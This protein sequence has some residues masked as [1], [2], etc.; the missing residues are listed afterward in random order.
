MENKR[1]KFLTAT[2]AALAV[3][4]V[5]VAPVSAASPFSDVKESHADFDGIATLY[6]AGIIS[7]YPDGTFKPDT[8]VT[9]GQAAK[10]IA[11]A[12]KL[13]TKDVENPNFTDIG[14]SNPYYGSIAALVEL[15]V[16]SGYGDKTFR[17]N[18]TITHGDLAKILSSIPTLPELESVKNHAASENVTR[19]QL[20]TVIAE[21]L[22]KSTPEDGFTLSILHVNDTHARANEL[23]KLATAVKEQRAAKENVLT[24]HAG[25]AFSGTLY[26]NEFHG[27]ADLALL[28]EIGF[29]AMVFGNHE[30]DLGSSPEGHQALVDF[31]KGAKFPF[32]DANTDFS[33]DDKF[34]GLFTDLISSEPENGKIYSGIVK[35][36]NGEKVGIF[37]LTTEETKDIASPNKVKFTNYIEEA[38]KAVAAFEGMGVNKIIALTHIGYNDNPNVDNDILL[39]QNVPGIDVIVGGHDHTKLEEPF[40]VD[41]NTV[42]EAKDATLIV[43]ANEYVKYLGTL[44]VTFDGD[45]VV[46]KYK[47]ELIDLGKVAEDKKL[48]KLLA[49]YKAKVDEVNNKEIGVTLKEALANP[50]SSET[51]L[52][53]VRSNETALGNIIT[54]G[55]LAKA[56][57]F[58]DKTVVMALQNGGGIREAIPAGNITV[59]QVITVLPFGNTLALMDATG[60]ELKAAF[61]VSLKNVP[62]ENGGFLHIAGAKLQYD[63]SKEAGSRVVSVEYFDKAT[64]KYVPLQDDKRYTVATNAYTAKGGDGFDMF[65]KAYEEGR[66]TDLGLSDWENLQEQLLSLKEVKTTTEGR[67]VDLAK[68]Q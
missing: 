50:R 24:L 9:R 52:E 30:F 18:Q 47:G 68:K 17:P 12:L 59:G 5:A 54:D 56:Q 55:M 8:N 4:A 13:D 57:K 32:V 21:A 51:S 62:N 14:A 58:T 33:A 15:K 42:G 16:I 6:A 10:M 60:A 36:I 45:G 11:G 34:T 64:G 43:Q 20:A 63:S 46:T 23:P 22:T 27:Q 7:G 38:E 19:G 3:T 65:A 31:I 28:N 39:A 48:V 2:A 25:D 40:V 26:F 41:T 53:S 29:D 66:V 1:N 61:E 35:E 49:P 67:I 37:G 44:D